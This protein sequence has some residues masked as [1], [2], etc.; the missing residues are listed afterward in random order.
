MSE[1]RVCCPSCDVRYVFPDGTSVNHLTCRHCGGLLTAAR[2]SMDMPAPAVAVGHAIRMRPLAA[3][4]GIAPN[5]LIGIDDLLADRRHDDYTYAPPVSAWLGWVLFAAI[6]GGMLAYQMGIPNPSTSTWLPYYASARNALFVLAGLLVIRDAWQDGV[7]QGV[8]CLLLP[9][10]L[11]LYAISK[12]DSY[13]LRGL[14]FGLLGG[15]VAEGW[16]MPGASLVT[17]FGPALQGLIDHV[18]SAL[19]AA[20]V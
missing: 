13:L 14:V 12:L 3:G 11:L 17:S 6:L 7:G 8:L 10:Y 20:K 1:V 5:S 18:N 2:K 19:A 16:F 15:V 9:P 4:H